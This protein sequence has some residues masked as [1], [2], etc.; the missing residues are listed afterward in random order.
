M[1]NNDSEFEDYGL[2]SEEELCPS[3]GMFVSLLT[4]DK[5]FGILWSRDN[6]I[7]FLKKLGYKIIELN[8]DFT[9]Y[10]IQV[11][12]K[13]DSEIIPDM[14]RDNIGEVFSNEIQGILLDWLLKIKQN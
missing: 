7:S 4:M 8:K 5:P 12:V 2:N 10:S 14:S 11:A 3:V 9:E 6:Q 1:N 13:P